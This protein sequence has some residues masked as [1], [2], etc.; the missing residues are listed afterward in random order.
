MDIWVKTLP[1]VSNFTVVHGV[2][3]GSAWSKLKKKQIKK[4]IVN[5][6]FKNWKCENSFKFESAHCKS[7]GMIENMKNKIVPLKI[8]YFKLEGNIKIKKKEM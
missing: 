5:L 7:E 2:K 1:I 6:K 4:Q 8:R 3:L